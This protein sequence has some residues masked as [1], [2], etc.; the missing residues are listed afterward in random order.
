MCHIQT[1]PNLSVDVVSVF[2]KGVA[3]Q[4]FFRTRKEDDPTGL[5]NQS[6]G[7]GNAIAFKDRVFIFIIETAIS[8]SQITHKY[9]YA[10]RVF[11]CNSQRGRVRGGLL[12]H[13]ARV[14]GQTEISL[15]NCE[16]NS[17]CRRRH[18]PA[19]RDFT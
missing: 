8:Q 19:Q 2:G 12:C 14:V 3:P 6:V 5:S 7:E 13:A 10:T 17:V 15:G 16:G 11:T 18:W 1:F 9:S 4:Q